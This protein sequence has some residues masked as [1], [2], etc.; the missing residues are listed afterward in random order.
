M[1]ALLSCLPRMHA[2]A[3]TDTAHGICGGCLWDVVGVGHDGHHCD[4]VS[5]EHLFAAGD[6]AF[7]GKLRLRL[8]IYLIRRVVPDFDPHSHFGNAVRGALEAAIR[9]QQGPMT[10]RR[11]DE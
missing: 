10:P 1:V 5:C 4:E 11:D 7:G 8:G 2:D 9:V 6:G 3:G